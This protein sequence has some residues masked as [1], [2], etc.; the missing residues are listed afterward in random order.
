MWNSRKV[1]KYILPCI[2]L[3]SF[4]LQVKASDWLAPEDKQNKSAPFVFD[5]SSAKKGGDLYQKNCLQ[6]H[7]NPGKKNY[8]NLVPIPNDPADK[9][10]QANSDGSF[11]YKITE[12]RGAMP[13]FKDVLTEEERWLIISFIRSYN[14]EYKQA[15]IE[16]KT[17][18]DKAN[19]VKL[20][21][22]YNEEKNQIE[23]N[24]SGK[25]DSIFIPISNA[26]AS[27]FIK[28]YFGNMKMGESKLTNEQGKAFF[29]I[30]SGIPGDSL[31]NVEFVAKLDDSETYGEVKTSNI[32]KAGIISKHEN[33]LDERSMFNI[34]RKA[35]LWLIITYIAGVLAVWGVIGMVAM[36]LLKLKKLSKNEN[37]E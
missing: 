24:V 21:I 11:F 1:L 14:K 5:E 7:G 36:M 29:E 2:L 4:S 20:S 28:R 12:G 30:L 10:F 19:D 15:A 31:G 16:E 23:L 8:I 26:E 37:H 27:V 22:L 3:T 34:S 13:Q 33:V 32:Y 9:V 25:K 17:G 35:P 6:C 18:S